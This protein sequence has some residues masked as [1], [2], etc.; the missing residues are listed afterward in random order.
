MPGNDIIHSLATGLDVMSMLAEAEHGLRLKDIAD[1]MNM[2]KP[3]VHNILRTLKTK[4]FV[5]QNES[6]PTYHVGPRL[7]QLAINQSRQTGLLKIEKVMQKIEARIPDATVTFSQ[8]LGGD[9]MVRRR[10]SADSYGV[11][12]QPTGHPLALYGSASGLALLAFCSEEC[13]LALQQR[14]PLLDEASDLWS[15]ADK[16]DEYLEQV[17][18]QGYALH[19]CGNEKRLAI[20]APIINPDKSLFGMLGIARTAGRNTKFDQS[21]LDESVETLLESI[22]KYHQEDLSKV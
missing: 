14:H 16:L 9:V 7:E 21:D 5:V 20:A 18:V 2:K 22:Q 4:G 1:K 17:R 15:P 3:A 19:P 6:S 10:L 8:P 11:M 12:Q 13:Y